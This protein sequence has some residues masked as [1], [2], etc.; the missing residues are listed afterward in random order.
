MTSAVCFNFF[1]CML[2]LLTSKVDGATYRHQ[3]VDKDWCD[4]YK[5]GMDCGL[6][7]PNQLQSSDKIIPKIPLI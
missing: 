2:V 5:P 4:R 6:R 1:P 7:S 3:E